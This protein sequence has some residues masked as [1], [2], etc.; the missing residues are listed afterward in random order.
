MMAAYRIAILARALHERLIWQYVQPN[1][2]GW[3]RFSFLN[4]SRKT[5]WVSILYHGAGGIWTY[6]AGR[7]STRSTCSVDQ[8][9]PLWQVTNIQGTL[10]TTRRTLDTIP[11]TLNTIWGALDTIWGTL[12]TSPACLR[13]GWWPCDRWVTFRENWTQFGEHLVLFEEHWAQFQE[14]WTQLGEHWTP[15]GKHWT[16]LREHWTPFGKHWTQLW[17]HGTPFGEH[18]V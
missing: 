15:F 17:E 7:P 6:V 16:Q 4:L 5:N 3:I 18:S 2:T 13:P 11:G 10:D 14:H 8:V 1:R 9:S 12:D